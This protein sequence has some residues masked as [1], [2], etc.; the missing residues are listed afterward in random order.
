MKPPMG[1]GVDIVDNRAG[2]TKL[3]SYRRDDCREGGSCCRLAGQSSSCCRWRVEPICADGVSRLAAERVLD[4]RRML[5]A[6]E[7]L[8]EA[9]GI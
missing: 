1:G 8:Q 3:R 5:L 2:L 9:S 4:G 7:I 6:A